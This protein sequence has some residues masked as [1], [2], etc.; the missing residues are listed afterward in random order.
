MFGVKGLGFRRTGRSPPRS[1]LGGY[2]LNP[3]PQTL[4]LRTLAPNH[5]Q[6]YTLNPET[7]HPTPYTLNPEP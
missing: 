1:A 4:T 5:S 3:N 2:T 6:P 7:L